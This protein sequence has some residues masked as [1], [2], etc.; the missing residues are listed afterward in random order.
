MTHNHTWTDFDI[1]WHKS[2]G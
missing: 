2:Y 1:F